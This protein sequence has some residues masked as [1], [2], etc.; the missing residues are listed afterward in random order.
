M[1][2]DGNGY[3]D[4]PRPRHD[5]TIGLLCGTA[6][7]LPRACLELSGPSSACH[8]RTMGFHEPLWHCHGTVIDC[9]DYSTELPWAFHGTPVPLS[10]AL[11]TL[12]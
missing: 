10:W 11:I 2:L 7:A 4:T 12:P 6:M 8:D 5:T 1:S 9:D 3:H